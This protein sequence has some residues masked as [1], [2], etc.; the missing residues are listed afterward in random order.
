MGYEGAVYNHAEQAVQRAYSEP[1]GNY[2][3]MLSDD[4]YDG[5][6]VFDK[7]VQDAMARRIIEDVCTPIVIDVFRLQYDDTMSNEQLKELLGRLIA[8]L[9]PPSMNRDFVLE[10]LQRWSGR[11]IC[12]W[13]LMT[14]DK[15]ASCWSVPVKTLY[16]Q[17]S[18]LRKDLREIKEA[19]LMSVRMKLQEIGL[20]T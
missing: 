17:S 12:S 1:R 18:N 7:L 11:K 15:R 6:S 4:V 20:M 10:C 8:G 16:N 13:R 3:R 2:G 14:I 5:L 19:G 9:A